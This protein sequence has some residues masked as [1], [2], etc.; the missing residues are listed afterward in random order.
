MEPKKNAGVKVAEVDKIGALMA[1]MNEHG[2]A[3]LELEEKDFK[4]KLEK[5]PRGSGAPVAAPVALAAVAPPP[6]GDAAAKTDPALTPIKSPIVGTFYASPSPES[7]SFVAVGDKVNADT[8]VC[9]IEAMKIMNEVK[10]E[11]SG[12]VEKMLVENGD[13]VEYGQPLFLVRK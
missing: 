9:I 5:Y 8:I 6:G 7:A 2:V 12:T 11:L 3:N 13:P 10:A 1:L 4:L